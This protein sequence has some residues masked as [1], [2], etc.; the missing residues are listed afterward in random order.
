M[1]VILSLPFVVVFVIVYFIDKEEI[2]PGQQQ[3]LIIAGKELE[4]RR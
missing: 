3:R 2:P 4:D 1:F